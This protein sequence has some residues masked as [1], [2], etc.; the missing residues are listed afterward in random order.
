MCSTCYGSESSQVRYACHW[1]TFRKVQIK[2]SQMYADL[3]VITGRNEVLAK[4]IFSQASVCPRGGGGWVSQHALQVSPGG[5]WSQGGLQIFWGG[6]QF[7]GGSPNFWGSPIFGGVLQILG[8]SN[9]LGGLQFFWGVSNFWGGVY[10]QR[11]AGTQ[12]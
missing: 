5:V 2:L 11:S 3:F 6:L 1:C 8:V 9:F 10:G 4:V 12:S 7:W